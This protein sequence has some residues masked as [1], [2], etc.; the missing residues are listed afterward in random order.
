[1]R[2][3][4]GGVALILAGVLTFLAVRGGPAMFAQ[5]GELPAH[6]T[7]FLQLAGP[8]AFGSLWVAVIALVVA[9][10]PAIGVA[11]AATIY[12][13]SP[14]FGRF[15][16]AVLDLL[17]A[18]PSVVFGLWGL[19]ILAPLMVPIYG[20]LHR[21]LG[22]LPFFS[23][24][25]SVTGRTVLTAGL[26]V[27]VMIL[28]IMAAMCRE[29]FALTPPALMEAAVALGATRWE[30]VR[31]AVL[32]TAR[33]GIVAGGMLALGRALGETMAVAMVLSW[34]PYL[35]SVN[36]VSSGNPVTIAAFIASTFPEST[37]SQV[38]ALIG[39]G[40]VLFGISLLVS[41]AGRRIA[42]Q[43]VTR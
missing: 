13:P 9:S 10:L 36:L 38:G 4:A 12:A 41:I 21:N 42:R 1:M 2:G 24:E 33:S 3:A 30:M 35:V 27:G 29:S 31:Y 14:K 17:A 5:E 15:L 18:V 34:T 22:W 7:N 25:P 20:W 26:V 32:P 43:G 16:A 11:L 28:P 23:G 40:L 19:M 37:G 8:A 6:A 39:L